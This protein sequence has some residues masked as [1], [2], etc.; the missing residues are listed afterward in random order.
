MLQGSNE[1]SPKKRTTIPKSKDDLKELEKVD[2]YRLLKIK[3]GEIKNKVGDLREQLEIEY[4]RKKAA[5]KLPQHENVK[6]SDYYSIENPRTKEANKFIHELKS[7]RQ[8][9]K[10]KFE[11]YKMR[12]M[13]ESEARK[14]EMFR[15]QEE[16]RERKKK[17]LEELFMEKLE[18]RK[19]EE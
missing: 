2:K 5:Y 8:A 16:E 11:E 6:E 15:Q 19:E 14:E 9:E 4:Y 12:K 13:M 3:N 10:E 1:G 7:K 18:K 17:R